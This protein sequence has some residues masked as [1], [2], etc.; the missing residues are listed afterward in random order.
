MGPRLTTP[1]NRARLEADSPS[2]YSDN[3]IRQVP[4]ATTQAAQDGTG[5]AAR[6]VEVRL[7]S[8]RDLRPF[9]FSLRE[10]WRADRERVTQL[11]W[12]VPLLYP[13]GEEWLARRLE[14]ALRGRARCT[15]AVAFDEPIGVTIDTPKG[16]RRSKLSTIWVDPRFRHLGIGTALLDDVVQNWLRQDVDEAYVTSDSTRAPQLRPLLAGA[17][18]Q[19]RAIEADR[20]GVGRDEAIFGWYK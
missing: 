14:D 1:R 5:V 13:G 11:L 2:S 20:Y 7:G 6:P 3:Q 18:F 12:A 8:P 16:K 19:L 17:G 9:S 10:L 4:L 15:V